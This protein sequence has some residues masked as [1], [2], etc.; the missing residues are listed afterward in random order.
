M[1]I[2]LTA[3]IY[4]VTAILLLTIVVMFIGY[5]FYKKNVNANYEKYTTTVLDN[6]YNITEDFAFGDMIANRE[7]P[8]A[9][10]KMRERLNRVKE[11]SDIEY[12]YAIYFDDINDIHSLTYA[13]N[14]KT[15]E[16]LKNGSTYT[17][18]G[19]PCEE[20]SFEDE[21][22]YILQDA[23]K[24]GQKE[25]GILKGDSSVYKYMLN[26]YKVIFDSKGDP[27][28][29]LCVEIKVDK[30]NNEGYRYLWNTGIFVAL[31]TIFFAKVSAAFVIPVIG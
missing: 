9:Y 30:I 8:E 28:G 5:Y 23:V 14:T 20:G 12:L 27:A 6:A 7:M 24:K 13:I 19:T 16:E 21:T 10:E 17:Y 15:Q 22:L 25:S 26:G 1:C 18:L 29:L 2:K 11:N 4:S 31:F 3:A